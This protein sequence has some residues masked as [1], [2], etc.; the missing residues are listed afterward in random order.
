MNIDERTYIFEINTISG[1][2]GILSVLNLDS[3]F[4]FPVKR[5]F[6]EYSIPP[7]SIR[8]KHANKKSKFCFICVS[9]SCSIRVSDGTNERKYVLDSPSKGLFIDK[10]IWK[11]MYDFSPNCVLVVFSDCQYDKN[12]YIRDIKAFK[13]LVS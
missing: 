2:E 10:M 12:E 7:L 13:Q 6:Y 4:C 1:D 11:E 3:S 5:F 8:G 9:G